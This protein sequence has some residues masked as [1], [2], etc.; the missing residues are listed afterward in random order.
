MDSRKSVKS[1]FISILGRPNAGKS[2]LLNWLVGE[3]LAIVSQKANA[4]RKR[5]S[6]IVIHENTQMIFIDTPGIH[7]KERLLNKYMLKEALA[8]FSEVDLLIYMAPVHDSTAHYEHFLELNEYNVPHVLLLSKVD[9]CSKDDLI[10]KIEEYSKFDKQYKE[11]IP[12]SIQKGTTQ[13]V[14]LKSFANYIPEHPFF[15]ENDLLTTEFSKDIYREFIREAIFDFTSDEI[16][17]SCDVIVSKVVRKSH[18]IEIYATIVVEQKSQKGML[19]GKGGNSIRRIGQR[20]RELIEKLE[21]MKVFLKLEVKVEKNW[22]KN[23]DS[24]KSLGY[25]YS[26]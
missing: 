9:E 26:E 18:I 6:A 8:S 16:P 17:Y 13:N 14:I 15:Y 21:D 3:K 24:M 23:A 22:T 7:E 25:K 2:S 10:L 12:V 1:G 11:L 5:F 20:S 19:I 4:T